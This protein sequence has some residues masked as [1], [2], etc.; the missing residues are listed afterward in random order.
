MKAGGFLMILGEIEV[1]L[2]NF[3]SYKE[4]SFWDDL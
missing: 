1:D 2:I 3:A 4:W